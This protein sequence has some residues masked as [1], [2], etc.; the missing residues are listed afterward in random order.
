MTLRA[1]LV[2]RLARQIDLG[3]LE[4][5]EDSNWGPLLPVAAL[6]PVPVAGTGQIRHLVVGHLDL[7][8]R[9]LD[10]KMFQDIMGTCYFISQ[11]IKIYSTTNA[12][13]AQ[14]QLVG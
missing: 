8:H 1:E 3:Q 14:L 7:R 13:I 9:Q 2:A 11:E 12:E 6:F 4:G 10:L 5:G